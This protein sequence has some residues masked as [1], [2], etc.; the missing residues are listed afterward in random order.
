MTLEEIAKKL[1]VNLR[2]LPSVEHAEKIAEWIERGRCHIEHRGHRHPPLLVFEDGGSM[3]VPSVRWA[4][5][6]GDFKLTSISETHSKDK[7]THY[8]VCGTID[9]I[10]DAVADEPELEGLQEMNVAKY[11]A[12]RFVRRLPDWRSFIKLFP[13]TRSSLNTIIL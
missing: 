4:N 10:K 1:G 2:W 11:A 7:T 13:W 5:T 6:N 9:T 3:E 8:D 12:K